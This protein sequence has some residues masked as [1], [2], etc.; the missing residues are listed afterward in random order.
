MVSPSLRLLRS[1]TVNGVM[2]CV[3]ITPL[4]MPMPSQKI[5]TMVKKKTLRLNN[6]ASTKVV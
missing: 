1:F 6:D 5:E 4:M 3:R 2:R